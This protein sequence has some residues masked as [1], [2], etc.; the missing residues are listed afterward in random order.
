MPETARS[1]LPIEID[2]PLSGPDLARVT[3]AAD[4][5]GWNI[6]TYLASAILSMTAR[7]AD[8]TTAG[9]ETPASDALTG[10]TEELEEIAAVSWEFNL[11]IAWPDGGPVE[12]DIDAAMNNLDM[13]PRTYHSCCVIAHTEIELAIRE[14]PDTK[15]YWASVEAQLADMPDDFEETLSEVL[16]RLD[17]GDPE[18]SFDPNDHTW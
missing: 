6:A 11:R 12:A 14:H 10:L 2:L 8:E 4:C 16:D 5:R 7:V 18:L 1:D 15:A 17:A 3:E 13:A 9:A